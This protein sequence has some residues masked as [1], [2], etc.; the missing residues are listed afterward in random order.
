M[1]RILKFAAIALGLYLGWQHF[2]NQPPPAPTLAG[3]SA[4]IEIYTTSRCQYCRQAKAYMDERGIEY[5]E[6]NVEVDLEVR[7]EF[8]KRGGR[9][10]PYLYVYGEPM[11]GFDA[12]RLEKIRWENR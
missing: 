6:K 7:K 11:R 5:L 10:V 2:F 12:A 1:G 9:G 4:D 8:H 3:Q